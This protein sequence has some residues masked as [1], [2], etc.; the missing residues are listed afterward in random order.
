MDMDEMAYEAN[1]PKSRQP[2]MRPSWVASGS[3]VVA[4][5]FSDGYDGAGLSVLERNASQ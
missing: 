3:P 1:A 2:T 4:R 5:K